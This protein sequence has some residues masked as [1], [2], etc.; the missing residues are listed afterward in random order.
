MEK[1]KKSYRRLWKVVWITVAVA[2]GLL[3][4]IALVGHLFPGVLDPLLYSKEELQVLRY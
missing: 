2:A 1:P 4:L 3:L